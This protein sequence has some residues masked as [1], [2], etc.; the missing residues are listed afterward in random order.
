MGL[1]WHLRPAASGVLL[2]LLVGATQ[3]RAA[4][5]IQTSDGKTAI[6][7]V[8]TEEPPRIDGVLDDA[9][10]KTPPLALGDWISYNPARGPKIAQ[11]TQVWISYDDTALYFAFHCI[12]PDPG[13]VRATLSRRDDLWNDDWIGLSLDAL[14]GG[15]QS[16]DLFVNPRGVQGDIL[17]T[18]T[19][20][21]DASPDW[22]WTSA[23]RQTAEGYDVELA[24]PWK[25]IHFKSGHDVRMGILFWR[26]VSRIGMSASWPELPAGK[27]VFQCHAPM[28]LHDLK[29]PLA[30]EVLPS[31][32]FSRNEERVS[33][34]A[35][36]K[37]DNKPEFGISAKYGLTST[38]SLEAT[39][40]PDF[41][42]VESDAFQIEVNQRYPVFY[43]EK[44]PFFMEGMGTFQ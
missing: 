23:G 36:G 13:K 20:G 2:F 3:A 37:P 12:D 38:T 27:W 19:A 6:D 5:L 18:A 31:A 28:L 25:N 40:N 34:Q 22:V 39:V 42:Q 26:R 8:R 32:T 21:E 14:G 29:R 7:V 43:S 1:A 41:S 11:K 10:W 9:A 16:Y 30:L 33:P 15:Q 17:D 35:F 4:A 24:V 44:R